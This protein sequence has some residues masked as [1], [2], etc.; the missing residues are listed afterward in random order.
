MPTHHNLEAYL[1]AYIDAAGI[2]DAAKTPLFRGARGRSGR[3]GENAMHRTD[4]WAMIQR[5]AAGRADRRRPRSTPRSCLQ[6]RSPRPRIDDRACRQ[7]KTTACCGNQ[8]IN[9]QHVAYRAQVI[10]CCDS[11]RD[12]FALRTAA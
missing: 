5:R 4:A 8:L 10:L 11:E 6:R 3:L 7:E 12:S 9:P 2:R 1:D